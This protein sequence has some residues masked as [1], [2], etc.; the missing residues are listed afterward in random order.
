MT[1]PEIRSEAGGSFA[2]PIDDAK[3]SAYKQLIDA[4]DPKTPAG[5]YARELV[6]MFETFQQTPPSTLPGKK[7]PSG[8]GEIVPLEESEVARMWELVPWK[9][10]CDTMGKAFDALTGDVRNACFHLLWYARE[11]TLDRE[12]ITTDKLG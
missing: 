1:K 10:E 9:E 4:L 7:H 3:L 12:P 8:T 5:G 2:P 6:T 11:L